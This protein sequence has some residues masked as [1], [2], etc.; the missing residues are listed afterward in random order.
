MNPIDPQLQSC[1]LAFARLPGLGPHGRRVLLDH[2]TS[3]DTIF[4]ASRT[5]LKEVFATT[6]FDEGARCDPARAIAAILN[7][8]DPA[9]VSADLAW[10]AEDQHHLV[11][12]TDADY[13]SLLREIAD[14]PMVL[15]AHGDRSWLAQPQLA[16]VGSRNPTPL[17]CQNAVAFA[18]ALAHAGLVVTSGLALGIDAAAHRGALDANGATIAVAGTGLD[19]I[20]PARN[21]ALAHD[22]VKRGA[23][24]SE[25]AIGTT[26]RAENFP[27]RNRIISGLSLGVLVIEAAVHSGS[28]ITAR[29]AGEQG[30]EVFA[31]PGSIHSPLA[32][33]CHQLIRQGAKLVETAQHVLE[34]LRPLAQFAATG[35]A[36]AKTNASEPLALAP[37]ESKLLDCIGFDPMHM[38]AVIDRSGLTADT[39]SSILLQLELRGLVLVGPA[40]YQRAPNAL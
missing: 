12:W 34:E 4:A 7:G 1:W 8:P 36:V 39:V 24:I 28:L 33:G 35:A 5:Q 37:V 27:R 18:G 15:Y 32:R 14:P 6:D 16:V 20:Y 23:I 26:A 3:A 2:F 22:I 9:A 10:L 25:F 40:G 31:L 38:D 11:C 13:P 29:L 17:G 21:R 19:R 30:R